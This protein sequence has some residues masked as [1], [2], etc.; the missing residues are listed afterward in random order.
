MSNPTTSNTPTVLLIGAGAVGSTI[1]AWIAPHHREF[2]VLDQ[3]ATLEAI[4][5]KGVFSYLQNAKSDGQQTPVK[6]V[7]NLAECPAPDI[8][9]VCVKN[10]SLGGVA[11]S[12]K[13]AYGDRPIIVGLQNGIENQHILPHYFSKVIYGIISYNA[14]LDE[15][16]VVGYQKRG[17]IVLGTPDN[18]LQHELAQVRNLLNQGVET[19]ITDHLQ[20]AVLSKMIINLTNSFTTLIGF[21]YQPISDKAL[22]QKILS[23]LT[24]EGVKISKGSGHKECKLGGMPSWLLITASAM[25]PQFL[26][27]K[28]FEKNVKKMVLSSMAQ[29]VIQNH[30]GDNELESINGYLLTL[31]RQNNIKAPYNQAIYE[32]CQKEFAKADFTPMDVKTVWANMALH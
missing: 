2:Y 10:Y 14:W 20:D 1:A 15:L 26:T 7:N 17:P 31:A 6:T 5:Q 18:G 32:L 25:L 27:R 9:L 3:G 29:D 16:G 22:F 21:T 30:R 12:I 24:Y 11:Q 8:I 4:K 19:I 28:L 23:Q 13:A